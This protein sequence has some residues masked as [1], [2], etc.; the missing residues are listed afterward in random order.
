[1]ESNIHIKSTSQHIDVEPDKTF[2]LGC[3]WILVA[4]IHFVWEHSSLI[5]IISI[6][7]FKVLSGGGGLVKIW[8]DD[9]RWCLVRFNIN[10]LR[11][12]YTY[13]QIQNTLVVV[14]IHHTQLSLCQRIHPFFLIFLT[15]SN[16]MPIQNQFLHYQTIYCIPHKAPSLFHRTKNVNV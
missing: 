9:S 14:L 5:Y 11:Q 12:L 6:L 7:L 4:S 16:Q 13:N 3:S 2:S 1:M 8:G 15:I 10:V